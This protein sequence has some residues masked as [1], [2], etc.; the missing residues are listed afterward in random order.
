MRFSLLFSCYCSCCWF[1]FVCLFVFL[2]FFNKRVI[3]LS[4]PWSWFPLQVNKL[5]IG[6][7]GSGMGAGWFLDS[8]HVDVPSQ[9]QILRFSCNRW[10]ATDED[11][12]LIERVLYPSEELETG[13]SKGSLNK[14]MR[15]ESVML[16]TKITKHCTMWICSGF[17][18]NSLT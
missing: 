7:D 4:L 13:K 10:L 8:V 14:S 11:D 12:G 17:L 1:S 5:I 16:A 3:F 9:G 6:H 18:K 2:W 15:K